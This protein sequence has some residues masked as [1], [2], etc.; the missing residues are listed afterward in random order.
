MDSKT[1]FVRTDDGEAEIG[2]RTNRLSGDIKRT[3]LLVDG[4][5]TVG[6]MLKHAAPSLRPSVGVMLK[7]LLDGGFIQDKAD[8]KVS[9][10]PRMSTPKMAMPGR[11]AEDE[12]MMELDFTSIMRVPTPEI[13]AAEAAKVKAREEAEAQQKQQAE[14]ARIK[15]EQEA[16]QARIK[17]EQDA[18]R[19]RAEQ[20]AAK[21]RAAAAALA[22]AQAKAKRE[23]EAL[24]IK[25]EQEAE[26]AKA[27]AAAVKARAEQEARALVEAQAKAR[28]EIEQ[29]RLKA[30]Q[31]A[32]RFKA[33]AEAARTRAEQE[34]ARARTE[35]E[36]IRR[37]AEQDAER[38]RSEAAAAKARAEQE[39]RALAEAQAKARQEIEQARLKAEQ[40]AA[41][42]QAEAEAAR[43]RAEQET[44][45]AKAEA[46][47]LRA[48][49][50]QDA[51][52]ARAEIEAVRNKAEAEAREHAETE[53]K[54]RAEVEAAR[55][56]AEQE[57]AS[58]RAEA[59]AIR[60]QAEQEAERARAEAEAAQARSREAAKAL[61]AAEEKARLEA[62]AL[63]RA[64][65]EARARAEAEAARVEA[66]MKAA[67]LHAD[68]ARM[69]AEAL[70]EA[71]AKASQE[72]EAARLKAGQEMAQAHAE[73]AKTKAEAAS[74][75]STIATVLFFDMVGYTRQPVAKQI[76]LKGQ[77]NELVS[78]FIKEFDETQR[79]I[80]DT[81]DGAAIGFLQHPQD[82][83][84]V[85]IEF[86][87]A[88][89]ASNHRDYPELK[90]RAGIHLGP[91]NVVKDMNGQ[92]N[93]VGD[94]INDAQRIMSF[95]DA[96]QVF[97]S[98]AYYDVVSR[99]AAGYAELFKYRGVKKDK[100]G[101]EHQ[102]YQVM[103]SRAVQSGAKKQEAEEVVIDLGPITLSGLSGA[104]E[105]VIP[106]V[107]QPQEEVLPQEEAP[108]QEQA[109][110]AVEPAKS[111]EEIA[112]EEQAAAQRKAQEEEVE[113]RMAEARAR[114]EAEQ[115]AREE[116]DAR[117]L[118]AEQAKAWSA[119]EERARQ[120]AAAQAAA[121]AADAAARPA[122]S[123]RTKRARRKPLPL[124]KIA[125]GLL[126]LAVAV[127][128]LL[129]YVWPMQGYVPQVEKRLSAQLGQPVHVEHMSA[130]LLPSPKL[131]L[132]DVAVGQGREL[133]VG[134]VV[135]H[136]D[137][138]DLFA[139]TRV[140]ENAE[141]DN[142]LLDDAAF[143]KTL[144]WLRAAGGNAQYPLARLTLHGARVDSEAIKLP[145]V[146]GVVEFDARGSF[147]RA[148]LDAAGGK[149][150]VLL[151]SQ[152]GGVALELHVKESALPL[153]DYVPFH[154]LN[155]TGTLGDG[156]IDFGDLDARLY[157]G[158]LVGK[159]RL[160]WQ[161]GW[162]LNGHISVKDMD[163]RKAFPRAGVDG[164]L[165]G[166]GNFA[167]RGNALPLLAGN[168][169]LDGSFSLHKG[170]LGD[171]DIV[172]T[173]RLA[174][175]EGLPGG[176]THFDELS[177]R[178]VLENG[179]QHYS[180]LKLSAGV[181]SASGYLD[182]NTAGDLNGHL[183]ATL[184]VRPGSV[185]LL[186][187]G[188]LGEPV[189]R[190]AR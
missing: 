41:R 93:M 112:A 133:K 47:A 148:T 162:L 137:F 51:A 142:L 37:K 32:A 33:E 116:E 180:Q 171:I 140:I 84:D 106:V 129:P 153:L 143:D 46:E 178:L 150:G 172:E 92:F 30:E 188:K 72:Q 77:F 69:E 100:H 131:V 11:K 38:A 127:V 175:R 190:A 68:K 34:A 124:G 189:L 165:E 45:R 168:P 59:E 36:A 120:Q 94:G 119:A 50:E 70:A 110:A 31:E 22:E 126:V 25:T 132:H 118:A 135:L 12:G 7:Q 20:E 121:G 136:F 74:S 35:A 81:G 184:K 115:R 146:N 130:A 161:K 187:T 151:R 91:V 53:A 123:T 111:P 83:L 86:R 144:S 179:M 102:V 186:L 117:K 96:D 27:E 55:L 76:E 114:A 14:A 52:K 158:A 181:L 99:L 5:S 3:L 154:E 58:A 125:A 18:A 169:G 62:A 155:A 82:A 88:V 13:L 71:Q 104:P 122:A 147:S 113:R 60:Q 17:A 176:R 57:A 145:P 108:L 166:S 107:E 177:G 75:R 15:A 26:R 16:E 48:K 78:E 61:A 173:T 89:T 63:A 149:F 163:V 29:A 156:A 23:M 185:P 42:L 182:I 9:S 4:K 2:R 174:S 56:K 164:T 6:E 64:E 85:A 160:S 73:A 167:M 8:V 66:E 128:L 65:A 44:A 54:V 139:D 183:L 43:T 49:A 157:D 95:A 28:Q 80:L 40:E 97:V 19:A 109:P 101:R 39:A 67:S 159:A 21:A 105:T 103:D 79:I 24:R 98:R 141:L 134:S 87:A 90:V 152:Q 138:A 170:E 10:A 1:I